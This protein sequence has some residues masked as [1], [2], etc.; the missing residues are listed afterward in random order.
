MSCHVLSCYVQP[1]FQS[2][3]FCHV[4]GLSTSLAWAYHP[5]RLAKHLF[6]PGTPLLCSPL[7]A[8][9]LS[10]LLALPAW[11]TSAQATGRQATGD[12]RQAAA[13]LV[14][15]P[16][17]QHLCDSSAAASMDGQTRC[18]VSVAWE[19]AGPV[20]IRE[21]IWHRWRIAKGEGLLDKSLTSLWPLL[22]ESRWAP[23]SGR[24][25]RWD[26]VEESQLQ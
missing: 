10:P 14:S 13:L 20:E 24:P 8:S 5:S 1:S 17:T 21:T 26:L 12:R 15:G 19:A 18:V 11:G 22:H 2:R 25:R 9:N 3:P 23:V 7:L 4:T 6:L 16:R